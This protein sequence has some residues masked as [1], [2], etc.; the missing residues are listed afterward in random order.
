MI[1]RVLRGLNRT[2]K[3][4][5][6]EEGSQLIELALVTP[7]LFAVFIGAVDFGRA[8]FVSMEVQSA[9][10]AGATYGVTN[11]SDTAGMQSAATNDAQ[12][13][14]GLA[15]VA[16]SGYECIDGTAPIA[17]TCATGV[18]QFVEVSTTATYQ[19]ILYY[20]GFQ[21]AFTLTGKSHMRAAF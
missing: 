11:V 5:R 19:P 21:S 2:A 10:E 6:R 13:L 14:P 8:Y 12:D 4:L 3:R 18:A 1:S 16:S 15:P 7:M 20:P 9:A 17:N